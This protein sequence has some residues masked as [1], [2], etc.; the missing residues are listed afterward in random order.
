M[1]GPTPLTGISGSAIERRLVADKKAQHGN[2]HFVLPVRIGEVQV[3]TDVSPAEAL[4]AIEE[5]ML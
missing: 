4:Q 2:V 1:S 5:A 3:V